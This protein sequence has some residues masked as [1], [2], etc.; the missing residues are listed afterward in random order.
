MTAR[1][2]AVALLGAAGAVLLAAAPPAHAQAPGLP[3]GRD[4]LRTSPPGAQA[5]A[6]TFARADSTA[7]AE[8]G[9]ARSPALAAADLLGTPTPG[10]GRGPA[11]FVFETGVPGGPLALSWLGLA[12][13]HAQL[14]AGPFL[15]NDALTGAARAELLPLA[16]TEEVAEAALSPTVLDAALRAFDAPRPLTEARY[17]T[18]GGTFHRIEAVHAQA[19]RRRLFG[20]PGTLRFVAGYAASASSGPFDRT[21]VRAHRTALVRAA[22]EGP[23]TTTTL[24]ILHAR[25]RADA[26]GGLTPTLAGGSAFDP[27]RTVARLQNAE[28][29]TERTDVALE[30]RRG[31]FSADLF[32]GTDRLRFQPAAGDTLTARYR[33]AQGEVGWA[34]TR[35]GIEAEV[36]ASVLVQHLPEITRTD[37]TALVPAETFVQPALA[38]SARRGRLSATASLLYDGALH[39]VLAARVDSL[40]VGGMHVGAEAGTSRAPAAPLYDRAF[41]PF[42]RL[43]GLADGAA[44][45]DL[46][47]VRAFADARRG[48][49]AATA[50]AFVHDEAFSDLVARTTTDT[51]YAVAARATRAGLAAALGLRENA[52]RGLYA[53]ATATFVQTLASESARGDVEGSVPALSGTVQAGYRRALFRADLL[54]DAFVRARGWTAFSGRVLHAP[55]GLYAL[56]DAGEPSVPAAAVVDV[57]VT[58]HVRVATLWLVYEN[59]LSNTSLSDGVALV[60]GHPLPP[61]RLRFGVFWPILD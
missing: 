55:T 58:A 37:T 13:V 22:F 44:A 48:P 16:W 57:G 12:P 39:P 38:A 6:R 19:R 33:Y 43:D 45:T 54:A 2:G 56:A 51:A 50:T 3:R 20:Q 15:L 18:A 31:A 11:P 26:P 49:L 42:V 24:S 40:R 5:A 10:G 41:G 52:A 60:P 47:Y 23:A 8:R 29:G 27:L 35:A 14:A 32:A 4:S 30:V 36:A 1:Q 34:G 17:Q 9:P 59:A 53:R 61:R 7:E 25:V 46:R 28:R 21:A